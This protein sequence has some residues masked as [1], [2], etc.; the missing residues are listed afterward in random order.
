M[1]GSALFGTV[2]GTNTR[3]TGC[4]FYAV[5][6]GMNVMDIPSDHLRGLTRVCGPGGFAPT[7]VRF[8]SVTNLIGN[9]SGNRNLNGGFLSG[10]HRISTVIRIMEYFRDSSVVRI[11]NSMSPTH[12][13]RAVGLRLIFS[14]VRVIAHHLSGTAGT[15]GNSGGVRTR[16][17]FLGHLLRRLRG[18]GPTEDIRVGSR[19]RRRVVGAAT[20]LSTGPIVCTYG[21][22]RSSFVGKVSN[23][24]GCGAMRGVTRDRGTRV[25]PVYTTLRTRVSNLSSRRGIVFLRRLKLRH[26]NLSQV[27]RGYC[28]LLNLV[29]CLATNGSRIHT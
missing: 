5:R 26:S 10:V 9:T 7:I 17:S 20:L 29:S 1:K 21:V 19:A 16:I 18:N 3:S 14:S 24:G 28:T 11:R 22:D 15:L 23:G 4:P 27:V 2:A 13:V 25:L 6:P 12:S 8:I